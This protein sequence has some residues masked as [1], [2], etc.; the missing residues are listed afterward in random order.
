VHAAT[1]AEVLYETLTTNS[2]NASIALA[3]I[4][5]AQAGSKKARITSPDRAGRGAN[6]PRAKPL[7]A[8]TPV[9]TSKSR[10][11]IPKM[12]ITTMAESAVVP[13]GMMMRIG[14]AARETILGCAQANAWRIDQVPSAL[15]AGRN[16]AGLLNF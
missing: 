4:I 7:T 2:S 10:P 3:A 8:M 12:A 11:N 6:Q 14:S 5:T 1:S 15:K 9:H 13:I 16:F